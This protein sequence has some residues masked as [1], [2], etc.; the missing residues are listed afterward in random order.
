VGKVFVV[1]D[2]NKDISKAKQ[3]GEL[4]YLFPPGCGRPSL[5]ETESFI[6][7]MRLRLF[8]LN[9]NP[10]EDYLLAVGPSIPVNLAFALFASTY[11]SFN[12]LFF[13]AVIQEYVPRTL[14]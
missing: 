9:F 10:K 1:E 4:V 3:F 8:D 13:H 5:F 14:L 7:A 2:V 6:N 11:G 12:V